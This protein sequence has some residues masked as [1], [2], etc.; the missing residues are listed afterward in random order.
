MAS[1]PQASMTLALIA[2]WQPTTAT[3][4]RSMMAFRK[5]VVLFILVFSEISIQ[6]PPM[7][8]TCDCKSRE[9]MSLNRRLPRETGG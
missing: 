7:L 9:Q 2:S 8:T 3:A 1:K 5:T 6:R 4:R